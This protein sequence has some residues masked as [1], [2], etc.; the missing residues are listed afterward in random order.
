MSCLQSIFGPLVPA[1]S[2]LKMPSVSSLRELTMY[3]VIWKV[4]SE[5][6]ATRTPPVPIGMPAGTMP[7]PASS[8]VL[9]DGAAW[10][11]AMPRPWIA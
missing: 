11:V 5:T 4:F 3:G 9:T 10:R 8:T 1:A 6:G 2:V 7:A